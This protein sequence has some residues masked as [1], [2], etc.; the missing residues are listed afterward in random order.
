MLLGVDDFRTE[1]GFHLGHHRRHQR[2]L[3]GFGVVYGLAVSFIPE[4]SQIRV[5]AGFAIDR[6]GRDVCIDK[7][8]CLDLPA[9]WRAHKEDEFFRGVPSD[10]APPKFDADVLLCAKSCFKRPVPAIAD[11]CA[12]TATEMAYS[13]ICESFELTLVPRDDAQPA[14]P[15]PGT[16]GT[17]PASPNDDATN[18]IVRRL[19]PGGPRRRA[20]SA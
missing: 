17:P 4:A 20:R 11:P 1:Q 18:A 8:Q 19:A 13:R 2:V 7:D 12:S 15:A 3:H 9:W 16:P 10:A 6:H 5:G 14:R